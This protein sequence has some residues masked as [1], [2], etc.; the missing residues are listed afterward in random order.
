MRSGSDRFRGARVASLA[1]AGRTNGVRPYTGLSGTILAFTAYTRANRIILRELNPFVLAIVCVGMV[2]A[3]YFAEPQLNWIET[4]TGLLAQRKRLVVIGAAFASILGRLALLPWAPVPIA[5]VHDEFSYLLASD[6]FA[7]GRLANPSHPMWVFFDTFHVLQ[8][9]TYAS[10][11]PPAQGAVLALGQVLGHPWIG[12]LISTALMASAIAWALQGW[13]PARWALLG[14]VLAILRVDLMSYWVDSYWGGAVAAAGGALVIG[15]VA[16]LAKRPTVGN[17]LLMGVGAALLANSRP[18]EGFLFCLGAGAILA[19]RLFL[20]SDFRWREKWVSA[21]L[22]GTAVLLCTAMFMGYYNWRVTGS[23]L[24]FPHVLY[25][26]EYWQIPIF[27][28]QKVHAF[29]TYDNPQFTHFFTVWSPAEFFLRP[30]CRVMQ[31]RVHNTWSF[32]LGPAYTVALLGLPRA[33]VDRR[34][35]SLVFLCGW[36]GIWA[37][38]IVWFEPHYVA[39][40]TACLFAILVQS[41]RHLRQW[42]IGNFEMGKFCSRLIVVLAVARVATAGAEAVHPPTRTWN[43]SKLLI[44]QRLLA[45][46]EKELV[47]VRYKTGHEVANEWVENRADI[48]HAKVVWARVIPGRDLKPLLDYFHD[49]QIWLLDA[50]T[51]P[52]HIERYRPDLPSETPR[53]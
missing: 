14:T 27:L 1:L 13:L 40:V 20:N 29:R 25:H 22:P 12:V 18:V 32:F 48:D 50:D 7:H 34:T 17:S 45:A 24:L 30:W 23:A 8:H 41:I 37:L 36:C 15:A 47:L 52:V 3:S 19:V 46:R 42:R 44:E 2:L 26:R 49:R 39:G 10:I 33:A 16:R 6:T 53:P 43:E 4:K 21:F 38:I 31:T 5:S 9:P 28:W 35:R 11:Y 51:A